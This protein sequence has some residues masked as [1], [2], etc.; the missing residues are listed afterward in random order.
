M[1]KAQRDS[2]GRATFHAINPQSVVRPTERELRWFK[3]IERHGPQSSEVLFELTRDTHRCKD[4][5][6]RSMQRLR[7]SGFLRL[8]PQQRQT[9]RAEFNPYIYDLSKQATD[10]LAGLSI[11][12]PTIRPTGHWWHGYLV[13]SVTGSLDIVAH[14]KGIDYIPG[15]IIL[16]RANAK[17]P[18]P[19]GAQTLIPDQ[20]F[21]LKYPDGYRAFLLEVDRS[22]EPLHSAKA[23]KSLGRSIRLY[24]EMFATGAHRRHYGLRATTV[25]L[26]V[27]ESPGRMARF[28]NMVRAQAG[29][30]AGR[31]LTKALPDKRSWD[32]M[33]GFQ[34]SSWERCEGGDVTVL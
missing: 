29:D 24:R 6:L 30:F 18:I 23:R 31:F 26:W 20:I 25:V 4:T 7:A 21:A 12:E 1:T 16:A 17:L 3:H 5:A 19:I 13:S 27:F 34:Q 8:P 33:I 9:A 10:H 11:A 22:T 14:R 2:L 32:A 15:H 28:H